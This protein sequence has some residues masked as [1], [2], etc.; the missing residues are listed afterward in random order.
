MAIAAVFLFARLGH[1]ALWDDEAN[2]AMYAHGVWETGDTYGIYGRNL[3]AF[4]NGAELVNLKARWFPP[5]QYYVVAPFVGCF[6]MNSFAARLPFAILGLGT[7]ALMLL[8]AHRSQA[9]VAGWVSLSLAIVANVS[10]FLYFR[11]CRYYGLSIALSVAVAYLYVHWDDQLW[12]AILL[13]IALVALLA[14]NYLSFI[15]ICLCA[16]VDI[17]AFD[18]W[19]RCN[20]RNALV[21][22][23]P[24]VLIGAMLVMIFSPLG[25]GGT[26]AHE[27]T[28]L[29][30]HF[31]WLWWNLRDANACEFG[32]GPL[33]VL[34]PLL[35][36][37]RA[38]RRWAWRGLAALG[39]YIL[40]TSVA[41]PHGGGE[42]AELRYICPIIPLCIAL[43]A[44]AVAG[45]ARYRTWI[46]ALVCLPVFFTNFVTLGGF[47]RAGVQPVGWRST[48]LAFAHE[49]ISPPSDPYTQAAD[50]INQHI[51]AGKTAWVC[52]DYAAFPLM[53]HAPGVEYG[54]Q[55]SWPPQEQFKKLDRIQFAGVD[56]PDY[57]IA[58]GIS[59]LAM[60]QHPPFPI[61][62]Q[63]NYRP[64]AMIP[65]F[66]QDE[67]KPELFSHAFAPVT[68]F[69][70]RYEAI[71]VY[72]RVEPTNDWLHL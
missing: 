4:Q 50:W 55:L 58:F 46:A 54:W 34:S 15:G 57:I 5:L 37:D 64:L 66:F 31:H 20:W 62:S 23:V 29:S 44:M 33:I 14:S 17:L 35:I 25:K 9:S 47:D 52:P 41:S 21:I 3:V 45:L 56:P 69:N 71:Y 43:G 18:R 16:A 6:G 28:W 48:P 1:Y 11:Q 19:P 38:V 42:F 30:N 8:W 26:V 27:G 60:L 13:A 7:I 51:A 2:T 22:A 36:R 72:Q 24:V 68:Q 49:L 10:L 39:V 61:Q 63:M 40:F 53:V 32:V 67:Y 59:G 65:F 12:R 70:P